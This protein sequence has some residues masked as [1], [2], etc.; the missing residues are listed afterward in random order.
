MPLMYQWL[1]RVVLRRVPAEAAHRAAFGLIRA[2]GW[3]AGLPGVAPLLRRGL[4]PADPVLRV[5]ALGT[6]FPGPLGLAAGFDKDARAVSGLGALGFAFVEVG[7]VTAV[8]QPGNPRPRMFRLA[9][10]RAI[11]NRMGF[12]S[13]GA[14]RGRRR[15]R[16]Q[17]AG[18]RGRR[19]LRRRQRQLPEHAGAA[20]PAGGGPAA[21]GARRG[22][23][24]A[25]PRK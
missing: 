18:G 3:V 22:A 25:G 6:E 9:A 8:P 16:G 23:R 11:V 13:R 14:G 12:N 15:L 20:R 4:G 21:A 2:L 5:R 10:D 24:G 7:T 1:Y 19:R 17:R